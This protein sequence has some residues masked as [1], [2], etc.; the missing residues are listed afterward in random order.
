[1]RWQNAA[2]WRVDHVGAF[3]RRSDDLECR[4]AYG[5]SGNEALGIAAKASQTVNCI[6]ADDGE[7]LAVAGVNRSVI[8]LLGTDGL[9]ATPERRLAL[10]LGGRRWV[11]QL[12]WDRRV[13]GAVL[14][15]W[16]LASNVE[17][18]RWLRAM[19]FTI[20]AT[21]PMGPS[22]QLFTHVWRG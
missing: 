19:G 11:D 2:K 15:N 20:A 22:A 1:M 12:L 6:C 8:W 13:T 3:L 9:T 21:R 16:V 14:E 17:S 18:I 4:F 5:I 7:P 10:A